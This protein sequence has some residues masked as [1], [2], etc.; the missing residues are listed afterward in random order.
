MQETVSQTM[1]LV[2][3]SENADNA[4]LK[5]NQS[6]ADHQVAID[7]LNTSLNTAEGNYASYQ[8]AIG[9]ADEKFLKFLQT[10]KDNIT[11]SDRY[12]QNLQGT[13]Q[14]FVAFPSYV[15]PTVEKFELLRAAQ[16][17]NIE[18]AERLKTEMLA[19]WR[20]LALEQSHYLGL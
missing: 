8:N 3:S 1:A 2:G 19:D 12:K 7:Q 4:I 5:L 15:Q 13:G 18:A 14:E 20:E 10:T 6:Y 17:G 9:A 16:L 11:E